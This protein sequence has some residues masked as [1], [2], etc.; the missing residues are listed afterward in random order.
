MSFNILLLLKDTLLQFIKNCFYSEGARLHCLIVL[1]M[2]LL[3][4]RNLSNSRI[5]TCHFATLRSYN[6]IAIFLLTHHAFR[7]KIVFGITV[8][9]FYLVSKWL[10]RFLITCCPM[11]KHDQ[12]F[13]NVRDT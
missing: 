12:D 9:D 2:F 13:G 4:L 7:K 5:R 10:R 8:I 11:K 3:P 6:L 1:T